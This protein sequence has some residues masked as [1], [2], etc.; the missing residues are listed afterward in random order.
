[1]INNVYINFHS[2]FGLFFNCLCI[3]FYVELDIQWNS[4]RWKCVVF[5]KNV[6]SKIVTN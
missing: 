2:T 4:H 1:M 6:T 3:F 5:M